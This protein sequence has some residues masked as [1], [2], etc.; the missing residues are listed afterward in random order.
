M[1]QFFAWSSV[2]KLTEIGILW[3]L[4]SQELCYLRFLSPFWLV[5]LIKPQKQTK[6]LSKT[7]ISSNSVPA[8]LTRLVNKLWAGPRNSSSA[9][10]VNFWTNNIHFGHF[11]KWHVVLATRWRKKLMSWETKNLT[12]PIL[13]LKHN[14]TLIKLYKV[15]LL[16]VTCSE[17]F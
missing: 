17:K 5:C 15:C 3:F 13:L 9:N 14:R 11:L 6:F 16:A 7:P 10:F 1:I 4:F 12:I 2:L 8:A